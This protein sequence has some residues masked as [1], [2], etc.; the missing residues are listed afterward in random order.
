[1]RNALRVALLCVG[2]L[3]AVAC[4][5]PEQ[6]PYTP[7]KK[8]SGTNNSTGMNNSNKTNPMGPIQHG[9]GRKKIGAKKAANPKVRKGQAC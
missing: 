1:M 3:T 9:T 6:R 7:R 4:Q 2:F 8:T 5:K